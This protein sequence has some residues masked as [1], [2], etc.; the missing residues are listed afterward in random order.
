MT[1]VAIVLSIIVWELSKRIYTYLFTPWSGYPTMQEAK[2]REKECDA[3][4]APYKLIEWKM[5]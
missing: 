3:A 5:N 2:R 1:I 4:L